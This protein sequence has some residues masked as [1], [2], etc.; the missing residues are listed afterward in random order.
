MP[1]IFSATPGCVAVVSRTA[2]A[3]PLTVTLDG[4]P[5]TVAM[6]ALITQAGVSRAGRQQFLYTL[7]DFI[8]VYV[9][10]EMLGEITVSGVAFACMCDETF[11]RTGFEQVLAYYENARLSRDGLPVTVTIGTTGFS[12]FLIRLQVTAEDPQLNLTSFNMKF[13]FPPRAEPYG[14]RLTPGSGVRVP[15]VPTP[16]AGVAASSVAAESCCSTPA[17]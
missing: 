6:K 2:V 8:Y 16:S 9:F 13:L 4:W 1:D 3:L 14:F 7:R 5:G 10:G 11:L 17:P 12:A 15:S